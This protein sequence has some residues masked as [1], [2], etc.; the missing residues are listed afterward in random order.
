VPGSLGTPGWS[1]GADGL[2]EHGDHRAEAHLVTV[3]QFMDLGYGDSIDGRAVHRAEIL[4]RGVALAMVYD[5]V[6]AAYVA[7]AD[8]EL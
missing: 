1:I 2:L 6:R 8:L 7:V 3:V 5:R 4:D